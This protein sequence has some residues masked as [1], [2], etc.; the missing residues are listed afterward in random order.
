[1]FVFPKGLMHYQYNAKADQPA[2]TISAF[3]SANAGTVSVP[4]T[5][6]ATGIDDNILAK[7]FK[8]DVAP[9]LV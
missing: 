2:T 6:F 5:I 3:G 9:R 1:M 8:T 4:T 7:D